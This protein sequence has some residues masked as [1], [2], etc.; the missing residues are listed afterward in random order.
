MMAGDME[1]TV[2]RILAIPHDSKLNNGVLFAESVHGNTSDAF[3]LFAVI[4]SASLFP[5]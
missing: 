2:D 1:K 3:A 5:Q 4:R